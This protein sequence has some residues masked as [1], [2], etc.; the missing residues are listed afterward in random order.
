LKKKKKI[1][2]G[3]IEKNFPSGF[4]GENFFGHTVAPPPYKFLTP[5]GGGGGEW[6]FSATAHCKQ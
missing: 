2:G 3:L 5:L 6:I 4:L 1:K